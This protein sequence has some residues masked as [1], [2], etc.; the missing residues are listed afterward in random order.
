MLHKIWQK[1]HLLPSDLRALPAGEQ[2]FIIASELVAT[3]E[4]D[5]MIQ[6]M[7]G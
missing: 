1:H 6:N 5:N 4:Y 7:G 2:A 3:E